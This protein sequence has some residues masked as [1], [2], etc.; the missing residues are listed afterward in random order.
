MN[1]IADLRK[2]YQ[3]QSLTEKDV[4]QN[5][6]DQFA[7]WW[8]EAIHSSIDEANAMTLATASPDGIPAARI[9]LLKGFDARG[10]VFFT[11]Y[12]S[13]KGQQLAANPR[14]CLVFFWKELERQVRITGLVEKTSAAE[15]DT[16]FNS[17][18]ESSRIGAWSSP[19]SRIIANREVLEKNETDFAK[20]FEGK[21]L[22]RPPYW[23]GYRVKPGTIEFWQGRPSRLHDRI[24]Y[25]LEDGGNWLIE[26]L[27]P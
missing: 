1:S 17:R 25:S 2:D 11:N 7:D 6:F 5:P 13:F 3:R 15:S 4:K 12:E 20:Q 8:N 9:V 22:I 26:R 23:G 21:P 14:A 19:Q 27:A 16:Y 24:Q 10:F 18:P